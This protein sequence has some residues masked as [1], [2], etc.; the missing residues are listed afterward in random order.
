MLVVSLIKLEIIGPFFEVLKEIR[1]P[2]S[3]LIP[4]HFHDVIGK[5]MIQSPEQYFDPMIFRHFNYHNG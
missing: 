4:H 3:Y 2:K 5:S 1:P